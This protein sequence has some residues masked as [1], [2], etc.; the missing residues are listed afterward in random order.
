LLNMLGNRDAEHAC[1]G[2]VDAAQNL[3]SIRGRALDNAS[4]W[5]AE[6]DAAS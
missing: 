4:P 5:P 2:R 6:P 3:D 1:R